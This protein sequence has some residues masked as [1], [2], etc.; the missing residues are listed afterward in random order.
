MLAFD[1]VYGHIHAFGGVANH[2]ALVNFHIAPTN[3]VPR[4]CK[5]ASE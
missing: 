5:L 1:R 2:L 3:K 4:S